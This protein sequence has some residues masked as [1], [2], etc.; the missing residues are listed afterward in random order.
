MRTGQPYAAKLR[1]EGDRAAR[2]CGRRCVENDN[3]R[4][5]PGRGYAAEGTM[6]ELCMAVAVMMMRRHLASSGCGTE[7]QHE[8]RAAGRHE[9]DRDVSAK[10]QDAQH[11]AGQP[12]ASTAMK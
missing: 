3:L 5:R 9:P 10:Q 1:Y 8:G 7:L 6:L 2:S 12:S 11:Q 4:D